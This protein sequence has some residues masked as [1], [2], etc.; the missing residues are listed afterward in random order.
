MDSDSFTNVFC[1]CATRLRNNGEYDHPNCVSQT[2][3]IFFG[4]YNT[5]DSKIS[6]AENNSYSIQYEENKCGF[7][8][9]CEDI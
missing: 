5:H 9:A 7:D 8:V 3:V 6:D 4:N 1:R 2:N